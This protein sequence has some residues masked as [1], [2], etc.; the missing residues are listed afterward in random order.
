MQQHYRSI[1]KKLTNVKLESHFFHFGELKETQEFNQYTFLRKYSYSGTKKE[2]KKQELYDVFISELYD[3]EYLHKYWKKIKKYRTMPIIVKNIDSGY[4][5]D[6]VFKLTLP[7]E[8]NIIN[9]KKIKKPKRNR[10]LKSFNKTDSNFINELKHIS[11]SKIKNENDLSDFEHFLMPDIIY[12]YTVSA[13]Q[14]ELEHLFRWIFDFEIYQEKNHQVIE[15]KIDSL[16]SNEIKSFPCYIF[17]KSKIDF[18]I[19]YQINSKNQNKIISG[20]LNY[21]K[22]I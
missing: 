6:L 1:V 21:K 15:V 4:E 3:I 8:V 19:Q 18:E 12:G 16:N 22:T 17:F 9:S 5:E 2:K 10:I 11:D 13:R 14:D 7:K 20:N